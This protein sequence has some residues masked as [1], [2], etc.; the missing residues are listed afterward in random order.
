MNFIKKILLSISFLACAAFGN[1]QIPSDRFYPYDPG[2]KGGIPI[3]LQVCATVQPGGN[4]QTAVT[5]CPS[6][7]VVQLAAG[8]FN[9]TSAIYITKGISVIGS[10]PGATNLVHQGNFIDPLFSIGGGSSYGTSIKLVAD[11]HLG[12]VV[13][14]V[15]NGTSFKV[16]ALALLDKGNDTTETFND[17]TCDATCRTWFSRPGDRQVASLVKIVSV[18][19]G[20]VTLE[21]PVDLTYDVAHNAQLTPFTALPTTGAIVGNLSI[22]GKPGSRSGFAD[23][24]GNV[25]FNFCD[26]CGIFNVD[27][28]FTYGGFHVFQSYRT[29]IEGVYNHDTQNPNPGG[30]GYSFDISKASAHTLVTN[31]ISYGFN[32]VIVMRAGGMG[33]VVSYSYFDKGFISGTPGWIETGLNSGH[34]T[35]T[36]RTLFEGN[37]AFNCDGEVRWGNSIYTTFLRNQCT[38]IDTGIQTSNS[39]SHTVKID[40][41]NYWYTFAG[42]VIGTPGGV[43]GWPYEGNGDK[44]IF[45]LGSPDNAGGTSGIGSGGDPKVKATLVR[46]NNFDYST[47]SLKTDIPG[48]VVPSSLYL[49]GK[50]AFLGT[51]PWPWVTPEG[52]TKL[53]TLPAYERFKSGNP[54][55]SGSPL[56]QPTPSPTPVPTPTPTP[57]PT[58]TP[59]PIPTPTPTPVPTPTP[60]PTPSPQVISNSCGSRTTFIPQSDGSLKIQ[61]TWGF[62]PCAVVVK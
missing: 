60:T 16:G 1:A 28:G 4:I 56:P 12:D 49:R 45:R 2:I 40:A 58:P 41:R 54:N 14:Q 48:V 62:S 13:I 43:T 50:P 11:A 32:K 22:N 44:V 42:N 21:M 47:N 3:R 17:S 36:H 5:N 51:S 23:S 52:S 9:L 6:G 46:L 39:N 8:T 25:A 35:N 37:L 31:S 57:V 27:S 61:I 10:G 20:A 59:T 30:E 24:T 55:V 34:M 33:N 38:G 7:Q 18:N 26:S 53:F 15:A 29:D 19:G